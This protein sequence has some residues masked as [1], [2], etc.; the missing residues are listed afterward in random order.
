MA[1]DTKLALRFIRVVILLESLI[2]M[3]SAIADAAIYGSERALSALFPIAI[4]IVNWIATRD[5]SREL[6]TATPRPPW[7]LLSVIVAQVSAIPLFV[8][9]LWTEWNSGIHDAL[10]IAICFLAA[11]QLAIA[12]AMTMAAISA[13]PEASL[14]MSW[15]ALAALLPLAGSMQFLYSTFY[16]PTHQRPNVNIVASLDDAG[17]SAGVS[18]VKATVTLEN[19]GSTDLDFF[20]AVYTVTSLEIP[21]ADH[22]LVEE[23]FEVALQHSRVAANDPSASYVGLLQTG[24]LIRPGGHLVPGQ[25][26][27]SSFVFDVGKETQEKL[28]LTVQLSTLVHNGKDLDP[29]QPCESGLSHINTCWETSVPTQGWLRTVLSDDPVVRKIL[30]YPPNS[31]PYLRTQFQYVDSDVSDGGESVGSLQVHDV[32]PFLNS[33]GFT[34]SVEYSPPP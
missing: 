8:V 17:S 12:I 14:K 2:L 19:N 16:K 6:A 4:V 21:M 11:L 27:V 28:R 30:G 18:R 26:L 3:G 13:R 5:I 20:D 1:F 24:R 29:F 23:E 15:V 9:P 22:A 33:R 31:L 25:K 34:T 32:Y 7:A 10:D